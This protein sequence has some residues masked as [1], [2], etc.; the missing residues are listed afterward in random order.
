MFT[1]PKLFCLQVG[2]VFYKS[3]AVS[4]QLRSCVLQVEVV[5]YKLQATG[6]CRGWE[7]AGDGRLNGKASKN[8]HPP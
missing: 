3:E 1:T 5:F 7:F 2:I 6:V 4:L 8:I